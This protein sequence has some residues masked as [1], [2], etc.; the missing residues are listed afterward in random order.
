ML[1]DLSW[2]S[3]AWL[4]L[5]SVLILA[6]DTRPAW[7]SDLR[8]WLVGLLAKVEDGD[9]KSDRRSDEQAGARDYSRSISAIKAVT[10]PIVYADLFYK[11]AL[12]I[13]GMIVIGGSLLVD[14]LIRTPPKEEAS[15]PRPHYPKEAKLGFLI[16]IV[17]LLPFLI[18]IALK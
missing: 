7:R 10:I 4:A 12:V 3:G 17:L 2:W 13:A 6:F 18:L 11:N 1:G 16:A 8:E 15:L 5:T 9:V 14:Y